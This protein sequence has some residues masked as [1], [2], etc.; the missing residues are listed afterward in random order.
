MQALVDGEPV[1]TWEEMFQALGVEAGGWGMDKTNGRV[2]PGQSS[3]ET[4]EAGGGE[5]SARVRAAY[6]SEHPRLGFEL[7]YCSVYDECWRV[8]TRG[9]E[10]DRG[11]VGACDPDPEGEFQY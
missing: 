7:C 2:L 8:R 6:L 10:E 3:L 4:L 11:P 5:R 1:R 9:I